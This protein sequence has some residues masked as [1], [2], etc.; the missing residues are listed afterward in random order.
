MEKAEIHGSKTSF[1]KDMFKPLTPSNKFMYFKDIKKGS[2]VYKRLTM[3]QKYICNLIQDYDNFSPEI[4]DKYTSVC[5]TK[6]FDRY[7]NYA[8]NSN[9]VCIYGHSF[10]LLTYINGPLTFYTKWQGIGFDEHF[11]HINIA[12]LGWSKSK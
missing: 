1:D 11:S 6:L 7:G 4:K 10:C 12:Q 8:V 5:K 9:K 2:A 3:S